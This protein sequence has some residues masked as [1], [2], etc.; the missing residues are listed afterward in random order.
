MHYYQFNI[1]DYAS[2]T[3]NLSLLEDL[4]Y[5]KL[6]DEYYLH[7]RPLNGCITDVARQIGMKDYQAE[8]AFVLKSFFT[9]KEDDWINKRADREI[10]HYASK[11]DQASR[12]GKASAEVRRN[13]RSTDVQ[14]TNNQ[15]P[16]TNNHK[17][18]TSTS[19]TIVAKRDCNRPETV[20]EQV[21]Y[22]FQT[23]RRAKKAPLTS[24]ALSRIDKEAG[25]AGISLEAALIECCARGWTGFKAEWVKDK[26]DPLNFTAAN[27]RLLEKIETEERLL[28]VK[29]LELGF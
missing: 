25:K 12:A 5:R 24:S 22:D 23:L 2:H 7:E 28:I 21:W 1:G 26:A 16:I 14:L 6:L 29:P 9:N 13:G 18:L 15:Q 19:K 4:A 20:S 10:T 8:V 17:T 3:R 11:L 27:R